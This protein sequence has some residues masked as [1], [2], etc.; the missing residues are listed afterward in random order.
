MPSRPTF[1]RLHTVIG[2]LIALFFVWGT[3]NGAEATQLGRGQVNYMLQC[4]GCHKADGSGIDKTVPDLRTHGRNFIESVDGRPYFIAVPGSANAPLT[5]AELAE[6]VNY[7][8]KNI[9]ES[10]DAKLFYSE[11][12][13]TR[14]RKMRMLDV[15]QKRRGLIA[16]FDGAPMTKMGE[17]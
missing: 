13:I 14:F 17:R 5:D 16:G 1:I 3:A 11:Q 15:S 2:L 8:I 12:E 9:L 6:V 7:I 10:S 4:Q